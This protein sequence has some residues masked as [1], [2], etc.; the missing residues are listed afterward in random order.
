M[1]NPVGYFVNVNDVPKMI[2]GFEK[3]LLDGV[4]GGCIESKIDD[5]VEGMA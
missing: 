3:G 1:H 5:M 4:G 2:G